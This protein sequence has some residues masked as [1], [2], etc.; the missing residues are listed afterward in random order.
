MYFCSSVILSTL[1]RSSVLHLSF[2]SAISYSYI[3]RCFFV[4]RDAIVSSSSSSTMSFPVWVLFTYLP[5]MKWVATYCSL[6][7]VV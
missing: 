4:S 1:L 7:S 3:F 6:S 5:E 2:L